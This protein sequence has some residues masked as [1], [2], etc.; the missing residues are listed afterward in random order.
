MTLLI[1]KGVQIAIA[2]SELVKG[3]VLVHF[4]RKKHCEGN[5]VPF[6][7]RVF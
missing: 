6:L 1:S 3:K 7:Q 4:F 5:L 2:I